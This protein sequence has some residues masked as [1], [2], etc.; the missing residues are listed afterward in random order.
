MTEPSVAPVLEGEGS[1]PAWGAGVSQS[2]IMWYRFSDDWLSGV[3]PGRPTPVCPHNNNNNN[4]N[5]F[6]VST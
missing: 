6:D 3:P 5:N 4:N 1:I 2:L